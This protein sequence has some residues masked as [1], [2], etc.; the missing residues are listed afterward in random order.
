VASFVYFDTDCF[1]HFASTF[2]DHPLSDALRQKIVFSPITMLEVF[3]HL[4]RS[5]VADVHKQLQAMHNWV[6]VK[7]T[8]VLPWMDTMVSHVGFGIRR[9]DDHA[10]QLQ[11]NL[12]ACIESE[13]PDLHKIAK[14]RDAELHQLKQT[15]AEHF[16]ITIDFFKSRPLT[17]SLF[18]EIWS[19]GLTQRIGSGRRRLTGVST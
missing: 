3:S 17:E 13:L 1:H 8:L 6:N 5:W 18:T 9:E 16:Q 19:G 7:H 2:R 14:L 11:A 15:Y 10:S 12:N 4:A